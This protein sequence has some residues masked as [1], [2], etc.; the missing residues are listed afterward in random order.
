MLTD[1]SL[2]YLVGREQIR[3]ARTIE[4]LSYP[5]TFDWHVL[6]GPRDIGLTAKCVE[7]AGFVVGYSIVRNTPA[8]SEIL[9]LAVDPTWRRQGIGSRLVYDVLDRAAT[10]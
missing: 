4:C 1:L 8:R 3:Q 10:A 7:Y 5:D 9:R 2:K 6:D